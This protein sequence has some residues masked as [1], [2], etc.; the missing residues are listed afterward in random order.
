MAA[1]EAFREKYQLS[2][3]EADLVERLLFDEGEEVVDIGF[4]ARQRLKAEAKG[5]GGKFLA[6][7]L[8]RKKII[9]AYFRSGNQSIFI[10]I[11]FMGGD[12]ALA[13]FRDI[14]SSK[15]IHHLGLNSARTN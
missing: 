2:P 1:I 5:M 7:A 6:A 15:Q 8:I 14:S 3:N 12:P 11:P 13:I 4:S 9:R 10:D